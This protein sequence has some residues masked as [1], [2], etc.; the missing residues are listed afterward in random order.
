[1]NDTIAAC[2]TAWGHAAIA[3]VRLS[4]PE[5]CAA[6]ARVVGALPPDRRASV[7]RF[8]DGGGVFDEGV[9]TVFAGPGSYTGEDVVEL[10]VHGNPLIVERLLVALGVR[11][12]RAGEFTRRA[13]L[14][15]RVDLLRAEAVLATIEARSGAGLAHARG[16]LDGRLDAVVEGLRAPLLDMCAEL[17]AALDYP[18]EDLLVDTDVSLAERLRGLATE[19]RRLAGTWRAGR[20]AVEGARVVLAGPVNAG[21]SSLFNA[22]LGRN[23]AIVSPLAGTTR[24]AVEAPLQLHDARLTLVDTA[25]ERDAADPIEAEGV[26]RARAEQGEADLVVRCVPPGG[27]VP[28]VRGGELRVATM[29]DRPG[30]V[31]GLLAVSSHTGEGLDTLRAAVLSGLRGEAPGAADVVLTSARQ[32]ELLARVARE[33]DE[34]AEALGSAG[35]VVAVELGY[36][37]LE[38]LAELSGSTVRE[39]VLDRLFAR[40]CIGK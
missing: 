17:E 19:A 21:K 15:G 39:A 34:A 12:A 10:S 35:A 38:G 4:G 16:A 29:C 5:A 3:V 11:I 23:R 22:L 36:A 30:A 24:D 20:I 6:A 33:L 40:F 13:F 8:A 7:R 25:G 9:V 32:A 14:A 28:A 1:V 27:E 2:A 31:P 37:A 26:E 18:G